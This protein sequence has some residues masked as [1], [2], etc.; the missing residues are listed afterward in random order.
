MKRKQRTTPSFSGLEPASKSASSAAQRASRKVDTR[1]ELALRRELWGR[2]LRYRLHVAGLPGRPDI[3]FFRERV[4]VFCDGD[5][6]H[7]RDLERRLAKLSRGHNST[8]WLAKVQRNVARDR[9][10]QLTLEAAGWTVVRVWETDV[11]RAP[12][13]AANRVVETLATIRAG[14]ATGLHHAA[15]Q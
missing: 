1:C 14:C 6:W 13:Q 2:G 4:V 15:L 7:G 10:N 11:L 12:R 9:E 8:Y 3:V 5:F